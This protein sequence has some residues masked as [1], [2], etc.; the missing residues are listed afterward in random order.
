[1]PNKNPQYPNNKKPEYMPWHQVPDKEWK[2][3]DGCECIKWD[4]A[5]DGCKGSLQYRYGRYKELKQAICDAEGS[6]EAFA[7][8]GYKKF[9]VRRSTDPARPGIVACEWAPAAKYLAL[10]GDFNGWNRGQYPY[11]R[12]DYGCWHLFIPDNA[13]GTCVIPHNTRYKIAITTCDGEET[14]RIPAWANY[15]VQAPKGAPTHP[16]Y[17]SMWWDPPVSLSWLP[18]SLDSLSLP[19]APFQMGPLT[20]V[21]RLSVCLRGLI[22]L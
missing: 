1:M 7:E 21:T 16:A 13:D 9:G 12:D 6:L 11:Q 20:N 3:K 5:L 15:C 22:K 2:T 4:P 14:T 8:N 10:H 18:P 19:L 17:D